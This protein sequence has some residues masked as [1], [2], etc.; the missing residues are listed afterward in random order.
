MVVGVGATKLFPTQP[1]PA[2]AAETCVNPE[3]AVISYLKSV[4]TLNS[5]ANSDIAPLNTAPQGVGAFVA[6]NDL[7]QYV[8]DYSAYFY[9]A[10]DS[11]QWEDTNMSYSDLLQW[12]F[13]G[14]IALFYEHIRW[15]GW[16]NE[17]SVLSGDQGIAIYPFVFLERNIPMADRSRRAV[18]MNELWDLYR[19]FAR[20]LAN[21][22]PGTP[23]Q[24]VVEK[25]L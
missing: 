14:D 20:R 7:D 10:P 12:A 2:Y 24:F 22:P 25:D 18:P 8:R 1:T 5:R 13:S 6:A 19:D 21:L 15:P 16:E 17:L 9:F 3:D 23:I 11:L 4:Q